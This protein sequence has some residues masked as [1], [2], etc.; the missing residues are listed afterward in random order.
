[1][2]GQGKSSDGKKPLSISV[3]MPVY[4]G[5][6]FIRQ[7]LPPLVA[8]K[9]RGEVLEV[10]VVDDTSTDDTPHVARSLGA[11]VM[12][13]GGRLGPGAARNI[14][15]REAKGDIL[16]FI[17][18]DVVVH[19]DAARV[20]LAGFDEAGVVGVFGSYD[21]KPPAQNFLSQYKNLVH[22]YYHQRARKEASTFWSGCGA[23]RKEA[24][25]KQEGFDVEMFNRPSIE[26]IE[27]GYRLIE[28][29]GKLSLLTNLQCTH[30]KKWH[31]INLIH[32]E[33][34]CRAIPWARLMLS[35]GGLDNDLNVGVNERIKAVLAGLLVLTVLFALGGLLSWLYPVLVVMVVVYANWDILQLFYQRKGLWFALKGLLFHQIYYLYSASAFVWALTETKLGILK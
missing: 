5:I 21:D 17:D 14:A 18:A 20:M 11:Q 19:E 7:S 24:F 13:S 1:M 6:E 35:R 9:E 34:F 15:A 31:F 12:P 29:G 2:D 28:A 27:L 30:L 26:D 3:I 23:I 8:M 33:V 22:H 16:W 32:T 25:L 4:N 10:I